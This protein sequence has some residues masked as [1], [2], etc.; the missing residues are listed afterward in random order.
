MKLFGKDVTTQKVMDR[1]KERLSARGLLPPSEA[2]GLDPS[3]EAPVDAFSFVV[4]AMAEHVDS[5]RGLPIETHR[6]GVAGRAVVLAKQAFRSIGQL[7]INEALARQVA[8]NGQVLDGY[9]Q[10]SAE[11][12]RLREK[13]AELERARLPPAP[14]EPR[15]RPRA[16]KKPVTKK[17]PSRKKA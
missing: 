1:V 5:T 11:V 13:V 6:D 10:L 12:V 7:F 17:P 15:P 8:F 2:V 16:P 4:E 14:P 3:V 9:S